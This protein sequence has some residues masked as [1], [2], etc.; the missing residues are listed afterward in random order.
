MVVVQSS[1]DFVILSAESVSRSEANMK[2]TDSHNRH[3]A[4]KLVGMLRPP[5]RSLRERLT[6]SA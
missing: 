6:R 2:P 3:G 4:G 1:H 5:H